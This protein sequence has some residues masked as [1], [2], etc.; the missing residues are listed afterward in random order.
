MFY[1]STDYDIFKRVIWNLNPSDHQFIAIMFVS[2]DTFVVLPSAT[3]NG[4]MIFGKN[5]DRPQGEVQEIVFVPRQKFA[6][7]SQQ[8]VYILF[9]ISNKSFQPFIPLDSALTYQWIL[10]PK[11][12]PPF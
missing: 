10:C 12:M 3:V 6:S 2:C 8:K 5:S 7:G 4:Q 9:L 1:L 11:P